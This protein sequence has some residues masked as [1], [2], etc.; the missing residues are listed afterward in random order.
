MLKKLKRFFPIKVHNIKYGYGWWF[1]DKLF[2][3][4]KHWI[5][6]NIMPV[7]CEINNLVF[8]SNLKSIEHGYSNSWDRY[9]EQFKK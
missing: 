8:D 5:P 2:F 3:F 6:F 9:Y 1:G 7:S 4:E